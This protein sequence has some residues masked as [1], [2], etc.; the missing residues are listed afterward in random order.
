MHHRNAAERII[1]TFKDHFIVGICLTYPDFPMKNWE[2]LLEQAEITLNLFR[3]S[4]LN[5][6]LLLYA[7]LNI[8]FNYNRT[9]MPPPRHQNPRARQTAQ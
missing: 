4:I 8:T 1:S 6:K 9:P 2:L 3:P 5:P 7:Q